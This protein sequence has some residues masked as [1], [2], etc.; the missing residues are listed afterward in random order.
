MA[1]E[2]SSPPPQNW[3]ALKKRKGHNPD[4][5]ILSLSLSLSLSVF[6][7]ISRCRGLY[8]HR[9]N[10]FSPCNKISS[11]LWSLDALPNRPKSQCSLK[12]TPAA[13]WCVPEGQGMQNGFGLCKQRTPNS[14]K[15]KKK[16]CHV[17]AE[18]FLDPGSGERKRMPI[19]WMPRVNRAAGPQTETRLRAIYPPEKN[20]SLYSVSP[21]FTKPA[22]PPTPS[23]PAGR[24]APPTWP[25]P[26][27]GFRWKGAPDAE[28]R[29]RGKTRP[30]R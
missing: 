28:S 17:S 5:H 8:H 10:K 25:A 19:G 1:G 24:P 16:P 27:S 18:V 11:L 14:K 30:D 21:A 20:P 29:P 22:R 15:K 2:G 12:S 4:M 6:R 26:S 9:F 3:L 13:K 23:N 7:D